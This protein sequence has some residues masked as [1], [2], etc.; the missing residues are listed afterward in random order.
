MILFR[1]DKIYNEYT[2]PYLYRC[3]GL[4]SKAFSG[5]QDPRNIERIGLLETI[6]NHIKP[7]DSEGI[8][9]YDATD[10]LSFSESRGKA[11]E[12]CSDKNNVI[13][14]SANDY[15]ETRYLFILTI[16]TA[17]IYTIGNGLFLYSYNCNPTLKQ[18]DSNN[19]INRIALTPQ[20]QNQICP[21]CENKHKVHQ[22]ILVNTVEYLNHYPNHAGSKE[23]IENSIEDK[24]WLVLPYDYQDEF[25]S[26]RIPR[27]D[28]WNVELFK[29]VEEERPNLNLI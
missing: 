22:I 15:E 3:N 4:R 29:G 10:F 2:K 18:T 27:A 11:L 7:K 23:A 20:L 5:N 13:L 26:T 14:K 21:I 19:F 1:G 16:N 6:I 8:I 24:E 28:F 12:W 9:Y 17:D 25:R